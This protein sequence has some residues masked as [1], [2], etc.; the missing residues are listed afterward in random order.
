M[1]R[2]TYKKE[3]DNIIYIYGTEGRYGCLH[4]EYESELEME[5]II[6]KSVEHY[7]QAKRYENIDEEHRKMIIEAESTKKAKELGNDKSKPQK[8]DWHTEK[9]NVVYDALLKKF[10]ISEVLKDTLLKTDGKYICNFSETDRAWGDP[11]DGTGK[12]LLGK[13]LMEVREK[14]KYNE[15]Q[16]NEANVK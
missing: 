6:Y 1:D 11:G 7:M 13:L 3:S 9:L 12:N 2:L 10:T 15:S 14:I 5:G 4:M 16:E 8:K